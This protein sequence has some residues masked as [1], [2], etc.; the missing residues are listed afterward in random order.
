MNNL[1]QRNL[2]EAP[3]GYV[4]SFIISLGLVFAGLAL[5]VSTPNLSGATLVFPYN[6]YIL[7][8][9]CA[10]LFIV[11][12]WLGHLQFVRWLS[13]VPAAITS[14]SAITLLVLI[15]GIVPQ[16]ESEN[17]LVNGLGLNHITTN[18][19]FILI[20]LVL[21]SN[22]GLVAIK[23]IAQFKIKNTG[24]ILNH[25]GLFIALT[26]GMLGSGDLQRLTITTTENQPSWIAEDAQGNKLELPFAFFLNDFTIEEYAPKLALVHNNTG[27][28]YNNKGENLFLIE[29]D[30]TYNLGDYQVKIN[31][32]LETAGRIGEKYV[33][34]NEMGS[35]PAAHITVTNIKTDSIISNWI[36]CGS[37]AKPPQSLKLNNHFSLVMTV[38]EVKK[39]SSNVTILTPNEEKF[40]T[41][42]EV[43]KP[44]KFN[45]WKIYQYSYDDTFGKWSK[46]SILEL[47]K[48]PWLPV[49]YVGIFMM[50]GGAVYMFWMG[51]TKYKNE[52]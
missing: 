33:F 45:N 24:F 51:N 37:F 44:Y 31:S 40:S 48:D 16:T 50:I 41:V 29:N 52:D 43:N 26:A 35:P 5:E 42:I 25:L 47:V 39:F 2:W 19:V 12:K 13:K 3:W 18:W 22:L 34:V 36:S 14:I 10:V 1:K 21:L 15:M 4:E 27:D 30:K 46:T 23:R 9:Y 11:Y 7:L 28:I 6:L 8:G 49:I 32:L 38:P 20:M 17:G